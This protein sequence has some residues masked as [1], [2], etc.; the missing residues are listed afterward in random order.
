MARDPFEPPDD[1]VPDIEPEP[2]FVRVRGEDCRIVLTLPSG[3]TQ[4]LK[5]FM[6]LDIG[7]A[8]TPQIQ[9]PPFKM[10]FEIEHD[11]PWQDLTREIW[12]QCELRARALM[13]SIA[14]NARFAPTSGYR[15]ARR[16][17]GWIRRPSLRERLRRQPKCQEC[18]AIFGTCPHPPF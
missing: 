17:L 18:G 2:E 12:L 4:A 15:R 9:V 7:E 14:A 11:Q 3:E 6:G 1:D 16:R 13:L 10:T 5:N 8:V